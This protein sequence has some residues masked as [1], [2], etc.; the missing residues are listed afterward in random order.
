MNAALIFVALAATT[1]PDLQRV[2]DQM[3]AEQ[4]VPGVSAVVTRRGEVLFAGASGQANL[5]SGQPMTP[6]TVLYAGSLSK[7]LTATVALQ[8]V[9][10]GKLSLNEVVSGIASDSPGANN[11]IRSSAQPPANAHIRAGAG[12]RLRLLVQREFPRCTRSRK[13]SCDDGIA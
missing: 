4:D 10:E 7:I 3:R 6:D 2:I 11:E 8:L 12:R 1:A 5:E 9:G 13:V